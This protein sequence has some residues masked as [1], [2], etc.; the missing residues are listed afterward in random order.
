MIN[1]C[2][3]ELYVE[4]MGSVFHVERCYGKGVDYLGYG[5]KVDGVGGGIEIG[6]EIWKV[7]YNG[8]C[9]VV[10]AV[11]ARVILDRNRSGIDFS[12]QGCKLDVRL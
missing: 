3:N 4:Q 7:L 2:R 5:R 9:I 12:D 8:D 6:Y 1:G 11:D 10:S